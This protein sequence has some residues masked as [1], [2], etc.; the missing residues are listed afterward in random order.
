MFRFAKLTIYETCDTM[1]LWN[2]EQYLKTHDLKYFTKQHKTDK[3]LQQV[4]TD[5]FGEYLALTE[6]NSVVSR[7]AKMHKIL[8]L[9]TKYD[10]MTMLLTACFNY[11]S[12]QPISVFKDLVAQIRA[13]GYKVTDEPSTIFD[14]LKAIHNRLQSMKA[15]I[16]M[17]QDDFNHKD[18]KEAVSMEKQRLS[19]E[20]ILELGRKI[21]P[22]QTTVLEWIEMQKTA[23]E[24]NDNR[25]K[26]LKK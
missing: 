1:P 25:R 26:Q 14:Q 22:K 18:E 13:W 21:D 16:E 20:R 12:D 15:Q 11:P 7:F 23:K 4:M 6:N 2:F 10:D 17:L 8:K 9:Q 5:F 24:E 19:V 3:K